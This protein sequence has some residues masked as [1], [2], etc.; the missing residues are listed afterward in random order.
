MKNKIVKILGLVVTLATLMSLFVSAAP[1]SAATQEW[2]S[3]ATPSNTG[4]V[5]SDATGVTINRVG[6]MVYNSDKSVIYA[7]ADITAGVYTGPA[8]FKSTNSGRTWSRV[9]ISAYHTEIGANG[10]NIMDIVTSPTN[11]NELY[12]TDSY[13]IYTS[14][15]AGATW[16]KL[17]N[18]FVWAVANSW[19]NPPAKGINMIVTLDLA[20]YGTTKL[21]FAGTASFGA[22]NPNNKVAV[23]TESDFGMP[24]NDLGVRDQRTPAPFTNVNVWDVKVDPTDFA[25][26]QGVFAIVDNGGT[27]TYVTAKYMGN[28]W[29]QP[30]LCRDA[31]LRQDN[32]TP[33]TTPYHAEIWLPSD[34]NSN[35]S[36]GK[37]QSWIA[38]ATRT[39]LQGD[40]YMW[41]GGAT[42]TV[43]LNVAGAGT[44]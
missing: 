39:T 29:N 34:F 18:M 13:E 32:L 24:W 2:S 12:F 42:T 15:D 8:I 41:I 14:K 16:T 3:V 31:E 40:V 17:S 4:F 20:Q 21:V 36:S 9:N 28:Q 30:A 10:N 6:Q 1:V 26:K 23:C 44:E 27:N 5:V 37:F 22:A 25:V 33:I 38:L 43:D 11:V 35:L 7:T 19:V